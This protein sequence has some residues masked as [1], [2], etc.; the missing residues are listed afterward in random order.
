MERH[1]DLKRLQLK[2]PFCYKFYEHDNGKTF[3]GLY[4]GSSSKNE[5]LKLKVY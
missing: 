3:L 5:I 4:G 2:Y 1:K